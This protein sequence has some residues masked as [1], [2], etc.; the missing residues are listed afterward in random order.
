MASAEHRRVWKD[1]AACS[2]EHIQFLKGV[3]RLPVPLGFRGRLVPLPP[4][5]PQ[6]R[7]HR[8]LNNCR[9]C[10]GR[11]AQH[12]PAPY[13]NA[14]RHRHGHVDPLCHADPHQHPHRHPH[15]QPDPDQHL[16]PAWGPAADAAGRGAGERPR[17]GLVFIFILYFD[18]FIFIFIFLSHIYTVFL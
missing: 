4:P 14:D 17:Q 1:K 3:R 12:G 8:Y 7:P 15:H 2:A 11:G 10:T 16:L 6:S 5:D 13:T 9:R 18:L